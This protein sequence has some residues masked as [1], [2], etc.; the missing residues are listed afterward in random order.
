MTNSTSHIIAAHVATL[1]TRRIGDQARAQ[2]ARILLD[3][4]G[5]MLAATGE[6]ETWP[7]LDFALATAGDGRSEL[8]GIEVAVDSVSAAFANGALA[9][10]MDFGDTL[11]DAPCHPNASLL[12][13]LIAATQEQGDVSGNEFLDAIVIGCDLACRLS[14]TAG[15]EVIENGWYPPPLFGAY[16]ATAAVARI[17]R[18]DA[19]QVRAALSITLMQ[20][21]APGAIKQ[22]GHSLRATREAFAAR[23]AIT[24]CA[25]AGRGVLGFED[26]LE[27]K[28]GLFH[29]FAGG[30]FD[31]AP[32]TEALGRSF[33]GD[34]LSFKPWPSCRG[35]HGFV[36][37]ALTLQAQLSSWEAIDAIVVKGAPVHA[38]LCKPEADK[39]SPKTPI[40][41]KFSIQFCV[42]T[43]LIKGFVDLSSFGEGELERRDISLLAQRI[44]F[45]EISS[46]TLDDATSAEI[47]I[48]QRDGTILRTSVAKALGHPENPLGNNALVE[49]FAACAAFANLPISGEAV[50]QLAD[51][52]L[53]AATQKSILPLLSRSTLGTK[54]PGWLSHFSVKRPIEVD[55]V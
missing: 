9:H 53:H 17:R 19:D 25:L 29:H 21:M 35:T 2:A 49:K 20:V 46:W 45:E 5:V 8:F 48:V 27:G 24:S 44:S 33:M 39:T 13:A 37:A 31:P 50:L 22:P 16:G 10:A 52:I 23:A 15:R 28:G 38:M 7:F 55:A 32:L 34:R 11:D 42:A 26:P 3:G 47:E 1:T 51:D 41:A 14:M 12:P 36:E 40:D 6:E 43:A 18:L 4:I 54:P 30:C